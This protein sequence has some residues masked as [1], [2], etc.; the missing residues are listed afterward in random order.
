M[1]FLK[2]KGGGSTEDKENNSNHEKQERRWQRRRCQRIWVLRDVWDTA[3]GDGV[4]D[5]PGNCIKAGTC[6]FS[7]ALEKKTRI[8]STTV[9]EILTLQSTSAWTHLPALQTKHTVA[10]WWDEGWREGQGASM[11]RGVARV[12]K[13]RESCGEEDKPHWFPSLANSMPSAW[14]EW[15]ATFARWINERVSEHYGCSFF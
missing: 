6:L 14:K 9:P 7:V 12:V 1:F 13:K 15:L 11:G 4:K 10:Y 5:I 8:S 3:D 2:K